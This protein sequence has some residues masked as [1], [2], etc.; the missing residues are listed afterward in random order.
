MQLTLK[1]WLGC[2]VCYT[3]LAQGLTWLSMHARAQT[4]LTYNFINDMLTRTKLVLRYDLRV[5]GAAAI[6]LGLSAPK[7]EARLA[8]VRTPTL[9][10]KPGTTAWA[11]LEDGCVLAAWCLWVP[12]LGGSAM[13]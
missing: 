5:I 6:H 11:L 1:L 8:N 9:L 7:C 13:V 2:L 10:F 4:Q 12:S 3:L